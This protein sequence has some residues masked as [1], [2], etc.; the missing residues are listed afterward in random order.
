MPPRNKGQLRMLQIEH[1]RATYKARLEALLRRTFRRELES[2]LRDK[3][4]PIYVRSWAKR[5]AKRIVK[6]R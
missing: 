2:L 3:V 5:I 6:L 1:D 4:N